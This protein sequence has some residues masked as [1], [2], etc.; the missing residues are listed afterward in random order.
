VTAMPGRRSRGL[1]VWSSTW[2]RRGAEPY[3]GGHGEPSQELFDDG[4]S[5]G[6]ET[7]YSHF[8]THVA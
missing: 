6:A 8:S 5:S 1:Q 7:R 4:P 2:G 3:G